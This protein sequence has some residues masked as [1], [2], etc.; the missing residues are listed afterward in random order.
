VRLKL[1]EVLQSFIFFIA[2]FLEDYNP[3]SLIPQCQM[4]TILVIFECS[5]DILLKYLFSRT[6]IAK[7]LDLFV[8]RTFARMQF[9]HHSSI[10]YN[11]RIIVEDK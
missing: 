9:F 7:E 6:L 2:T 4:L 11:S 10:H 5:D 8:L 3:S 1:S